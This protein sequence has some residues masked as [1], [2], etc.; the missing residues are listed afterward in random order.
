M[1]QVQLTDG[2]LVGLAETITNITQV[3]TDPLEIHHKY[4][5][6]KVGILS[7]DKV[8]DLRK[9][10]STRHCYRQFSDLPD[11]KPSFK[12]TIC[13]FSKGFFDLKKRK[14]SAYCFQSPFLPSLFFLRKH[15]IPRCLSVSL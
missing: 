9:K 3:V 7:S 8:H 6:F 11:W 4:K 12:P 5:V 15:K 13:L 2:F 10:T 1:L 14:S